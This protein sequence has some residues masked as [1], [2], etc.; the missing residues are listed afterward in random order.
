MKDRDPSVQTPK[1]CIKAY[2]LNVC[3]HEKKGKGRIGSKRDVAECVNYECPL[4]DYRTGM[5]RRKKSVISVKTKEERIARLERAR[6][7]V[8]V[9]ERR[10]EETQNSLARYI[11]AEDGRLNRL[12]RKSEEATANLI[13]RLEAEIEVRQERIKNADS[14]WRKKYDER[15][16]LGRKYIA[17]RERKVEIAKENLKERKEAVRKMEIKFNEELEAGIWQ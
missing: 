10:L 15:L 9:A 17:E 11:A 5:G 12:Q 1:K 6:Y 13:K 8:A 7:R 14:V 2:C 16:E 4:R 3:T